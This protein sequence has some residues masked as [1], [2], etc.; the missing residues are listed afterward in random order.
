MNGNF[1]KLLKIL[2]TSWIPLEKKGPFVTEA[3]FRPAISETILYEKNIA[4]IIKSWMTRMG[5]E[6]TN[7]RPQFFRIV[8]YSGS[9]LL[10]TIP[11]AVSHWLYSVSSSII[12][13]KEQIN[14][15]VTYKW[16]VPLSQGTIVS[17]AAS[18]SQIFLSIH[19]SFTIRP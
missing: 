7:S 11:N 4:D 12:R 14:M 13:K 16:V 10:V 5:I 1:W 3:V 9:P 15:E 6:H 18:Y 8:K 2:E 19:I 17:V